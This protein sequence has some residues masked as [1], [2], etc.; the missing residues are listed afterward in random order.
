[1]ENYTPQCQYAARHHDGRFACL[2]DTDLPCP[3]ERIAKLEQELREWQWKC[4]HALEALSA[5]D[6]SLMTY[7]SQTKADER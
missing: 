2:Q 5:I 1:M 6:L 7:R 4:A 3:Y